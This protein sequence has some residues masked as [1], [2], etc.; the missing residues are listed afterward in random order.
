MRNKMKLNVLVFLASGL[1]FSAKMYAFVD[2]TCPAVAPNMQCVPG[3]PSNPQWYI[4]NGIGTQNLQYAI[5]MQN[6][7]SIVSKALRGDPIETIVVPSCFVMT[8]NCGNPWGASLDSR[9]QGTYLRM[10]VSSTGGNDANGNFIFPNQSDPNYTL[11][12]HPDYCGCGDYNASG[13]EYCN[14]GRIVKAIYAGQPYDSIYN[15]QSPTPP[16]LPCASGTYPPGTPNSAGFWV[17]NLT[18]PNGQIPPAGNYTGT[19]SV[20]LEQSPN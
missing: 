15:P 19:L 1:I 7:G 16:F 4:A 9:T 3:L 10:T 11:V 20:Q 18:S 13:T 17:L 12:A 5:G 8:M 14:P 2:S 6:Y